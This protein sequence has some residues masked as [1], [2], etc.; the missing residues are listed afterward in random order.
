MRRRVRSPCMDTT[1]ANPEQAAIVAALRELTAGPERHTPWMS[2][3]EL[4]QSVG[5]TGPHDPNFEAAIQ[6][7]YAAGTIRLMTGGGASGSSFYK[8]MLIP[9]A[10]VSADSDSDDDPAEDA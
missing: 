3:A 8:A 2:A 7:L 6:G 5:A 1:Q 10:Q 4:A 9:P